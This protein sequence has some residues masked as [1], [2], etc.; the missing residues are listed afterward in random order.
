MSADDAFSIGVVG[1]G[2][3]GRALAGLLAVNGRPVLI[4]SQSSGAVE[5]L[6]RQ[7]RGVADGAPPNGLHTT[8]DPAELAARAHFI[9][10]AVPSTQVR[11]RL[12]ALGQ[13][14]DGRHMVLHTVG[15]LAAPEGKRVSELIADETPVKRLGALAGPALP[16]D[17]RDGRYAS[18][19]AASLFEEVTAE[20]RRLLALPPRLRLY[21]SSD[22]L[23]VELSAMLATAYTMALGVSEA[24]QI[25]AG[26]RAVLLTRIV[27]EG[28]R[29]VSAAGGEPRTFAG[30]SGLGNLL[31]HSASETR[32]GSASFRLGLRL[33]RREQPMAGEREPV[34]VRATAAALAL[35]HRLGQRAPLLEGMAAVL[36]GKLDP[37]QAAA[38]AADTVAREE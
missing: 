35:A 13:H 19:V 23:G 14:L 7:E 18:M 34:A 5:E 22:L 20:A 28:I 21:C 38:R 30:L 27:A 2:S 17:L 9:I 11:D 3:F 16:R 8:A 10:V 1:A 33:G 31:V 4:W 15:D 24:L 25:G 32:E 6:S 12:R 36:A 26:P 29:L 37:E